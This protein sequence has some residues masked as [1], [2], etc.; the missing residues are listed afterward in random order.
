MADEV[1]T[2]TAANSPIIHRRCNIQQEQEVSWKTNEP[3]PRH[4]QSQQLHAKPSCPWLLTTPASTR[5]PVGSCRG[6]ATLETLARM[7]KI[8]GHRCWLKLQRRLS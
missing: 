8:W 7:I 5:T 2:D 4:D 1:H 6:E 3:R